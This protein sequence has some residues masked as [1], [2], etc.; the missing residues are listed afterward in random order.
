MISV[1]NLMFTVRPVILNNLLK[2][3]GSHLGSYWRAITNKWK[4]EGIQYYEISLPVGWSTEYSSGV[5]YCI[6]MRMRDLFPCI[7]EEIKTIFGLPRC[8]LHR[9]NID[10]QEY[11]IY[12]VPI[13]TS[14]DVIWETPLNRLDSKHQL[15]RNPSFRKE[16]QKVIAFCDILALNKTG[17]PAIRIRLGSNG[18]YV[19]I[20]INE[21]TTTLSK[22]SDYDYSIITKTLFSKWVGE[23]TS[24]SNV[25]KDMVHY[26]STNDQTEIPPIRG[27]E[28]N[29]LSV[30]S[31]E[32]RAKV[33]AAI[34]RY[35]VNYIWYSNFIINRMS[36]YLL[37]L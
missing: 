29:N 14:G 8:G 13:S 4:L 17:E 1:I 36:R 12:Y 24:L 25:V 33:E 22:A 15:R 21:A 32:I 34:K 27:A 10:Y 23:E 11:I 20:S 28:P 3:D 35:D 31:S 9:I 26:H 18:S 5:I 16:V 30:I 2:W 19:P 6:A 7:V 37:A